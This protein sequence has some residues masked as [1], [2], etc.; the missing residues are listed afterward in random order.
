MRRMSTLRGTTVDLG[1]FAAY[2]STP[3][4]GVAIK[5]GLVVVHEIWGLVDHVKDVADRFAAQGYVVYAPD[6][7]SH[8]GVTPEVGAELQR[9][10]ES[11]DEAERTRMQ[12]MMR[13]AMTA[14][15]QP[16]YGVWAV[17]A[18]RRVVD[19]LDQEP[20]VDGRV[21][22]LGFCFGGSYTFALAAA[23][24]RVQ[25]AAPFYGSPP[26][27]A[28]V[29]RIAC[30][31]HAYYGHQDARLMDGLPDVEKA[32]ADAGVAF[33]ATVY[34]GAGHA[35]FNDT[36]SH[37]YTPEAASAAWT[38]VLAFFDGALAARA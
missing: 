4:E 17:G 3:P 26:A 12:P 36:N 28:D 19:A 33:E 38:S 25:A 20:G 14:A 10:R 21:A 16:E 9:L 24:P 1:D 7:L 29:A 23:D 30:P 8:G 15:N 5:G 11:A 27:S 22:A 6:I 31:V 13:E 32:M 18:L 37:A 2:R 34:E 35:F